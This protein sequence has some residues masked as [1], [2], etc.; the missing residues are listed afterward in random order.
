MDIHHSILFKSCHM[1][2]HY[3]NSVCFM[4]MH[5]FDSVKFVSAPVSHVHILAL[6]A[7]YL[8]TYV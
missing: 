7:A 4:D 5:H 2:I 1:D 3:F 8:Y 6:T